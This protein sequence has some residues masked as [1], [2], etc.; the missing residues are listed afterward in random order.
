MKEIRLSKKEIQNR[1]NTLRIKPEGLEPRKYGVTTKY[2]I[3]NE[4][5]WSRRVDYEA[6]VSMNVRNGMGEIEIR[7]E[8]VFYNQHEPN[9]VNEILAN[10]ITKS[11]YPIKTHI[12]E[13]GISS[14]EIINHSDIIQRWHS[15]KNIILQKYASR[16]LDDFF[17]VTE[18][19]YT[20]KAKLE[21]NLQYDWFWNLFF[22]PKFINY[23]DKRTVETDLYLAVIPYQS[24]VLFSGI[25]KIEKI[26]TAYHSFQI[27]FQSHEK[28]APR[29]FYPINWKDENK[30]LMSLNVSF[31]LD[32]YYHFPMHTIANLEVYSKNWKDEKEII[33]RI[34]FTMYQQDTSMFEGM[35]LSNDSPFITGGL[36]KLPPNKWGFDNFENLENDW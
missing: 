21:R 13:K 6:I 15:E 11:L 12:N 22:H 25:Q 1:L 7:K 30:V 2:F 32:L 28:E 18:K 29:Y 10:A 34:Q 35:Q 19:T 14:N 36:V 8:N 24:P 20:N 9:L 3:K 27:T 17:E 16:D 4:T 33:S 5:Q 26:P 31:D 23:R